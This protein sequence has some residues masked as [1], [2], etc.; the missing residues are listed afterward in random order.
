MEEYLPPIITKLK[1]DLSDLV[2]GL[3]IGRAHV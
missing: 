2:S 1:A 3:E